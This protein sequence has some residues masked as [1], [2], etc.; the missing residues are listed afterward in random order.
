MSLGRAMALGIGVCLGWLGAQDCPPTLRV[1]PN[2]TVAGSLNAANCQL[3][4]QTPY[5][6]Y[7]LDLPVRGQI[8]IELGENPADLVLTLRNASGMRLDSGASLLRPIEAGSYTLLVNG[9]AAGQ[10]GNYT[11]KTSF[12]S[13]PGVLCSNFPNIGVRQTL[14]GSIPGSGCLSFDGTPYEAYTMTTDGA[15]T[16]TVAVS[17]QGFT[18]VIAVRSIDGRPL[19]L[20]S[21]SPVNVVLEGDSQYLVVISSAD[22]STGAFQIVNSYQ[23]ADNETCRPSKTLA[24][25]DTDSNAITAASCVRTIAGSGD[26]SYYNYYNLTL[27]DG[28]TVNVSAVS[29][30]FAATVNLLDAGGNLLA[31]DSGGGGA[32]A[33]DSVE[34]SLRTQLPAGTYRLEVFSDL[35]SGGNYALRYDFQAGNPQPCKTSALNLGDQLDSA[36]TGTSCRTSAGLS[37]LYAFTLPSAGTVDLELRSGMFATVLAIRDSKENLIV[38]DDEVDGLGAAHVTADLPAGA[39]TLVG[40]ANAGSGNYHLGSKFTAHDIP[41]CSFAQALDLNGGFIQRLGPRSCTGANGR[42][43]DYYTFTLA[44]D[45]LVLAVLTSGELDG[46]LTLYDAG[47]NVVRSDDNT[48]GSNDPLIVQYLPAGSYKLAARAASATVGGLYEVDLR[49]VSGTRPPLCTP[50]STVTPGATVTGTITYTA[51][52][53][54]DNSFADLYQMNLSADAGI[55]LRLNSSEFDSYLVLLDSKGAVIDEDDDGGGNTNSRITRNLAAGTYYIAAKPFGDYTSHGAYTLITN[56][57]SQ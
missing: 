19:T 44:V 4:D 14:D 13:E 46:Y 10:T 3:I 17:S 27:T 23:T 30:D 9:R 38:R 25:P 49:T 34:S 31:S 15:G 43:V 32:D 57:I 24:A 36:L 12:T 20:P 22:T 52:Q 54:T 1:P 51:C 40:G 18:P 26:Q 21:A 53:Y 48:Y 50:K 5:A 33:Q 29:G 42:P 6:A 28:G 47:G 56:T 55:D 39:Y 41:A 7:R 45:S 37:D 8:K 16:L 11:V 35:P 2:G